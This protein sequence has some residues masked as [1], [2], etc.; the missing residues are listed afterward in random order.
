MTHR[1]HSDETL[2]IFIES[3]N[4]F[5]PIIKFIEEFSKMSIYVLDVTIDI[6]NGILKNDLF[7]K[8]TDMD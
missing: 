1:E 5:H 4:E 6:E 3:F 2:N 7:V 8:P